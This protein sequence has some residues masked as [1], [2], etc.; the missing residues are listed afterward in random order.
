MGAAPDPPLVAD[1]LSYILLASLVYLFVY[2]LRLRQHLA[3]R[4]REVLP[5][6]VEARADEP[7]KPNEKPEFIIEPSPVPGQRIQFPTIA[8]CD[9]ELDLSVVL[10]VRNPGPGLVSVLQSFVNHLDNRGDL[11]YE[12]LVVDVC[13]RDTTRAD[14]IAF[15]EKHK[16]VRVL[17]IPF[18]CL[19]NVA[20]V[21]GILRTRG[22]LV[23]LY[24]VTDGV[25]ISLL[26]EYEATTARAQRKNKRAV[27]CG[28]WE[29]EEEDD[30][31]DGVM[32]RST[33]N[34][35]MEWLEQWLLGWLVASDICRHSRTFMMTRE[36]VDLIGSTLQ[37]PA[38]SYDLELL[39][40]AVRTG[41]RVKSVQLPVSDPRQCKLESM[42]RVDNVVSLV[43]AIF[44][45]YT[46]SW[47]IYRTV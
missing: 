27:V 41:M 45:Y 30:E 20:V 22:K 42:D 40:I 35:A 6:P 14:A 18:R 31:D 3:H 39:V 2:A 33:L 9:A 43:V 38:E 10:P 26:D 23:Y 8:E 32:R 16:E 12:I 46:G 19:M 24:N 34:W 1:L 15:A 44:M 7:Q 28:T 37:I 5:L 36:A 25:P 13:S 47:R 17:H 29:E 21:I 4:K 11:R